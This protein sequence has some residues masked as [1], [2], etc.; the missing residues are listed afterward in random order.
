MSEQPSH[1]EN[2]AIFFMGKEGREGNIIMFDLRS[3]IVCLRYGP[4]K[5]LPNENFLS[6]CVLCAQLYPTLCDPMNCSPPGSTVY[7]ISQARILGRV[8][9]PFSKGSPQSRGWTRVSVSCIGRQI[10]YH[11]ATWEVMGSY[12]LLHR[13]DYNSVGVYWLLSMYRYFTHIPSLIL[14][15]CPWTGRSPCR[16]RQ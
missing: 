4:P 15:A 12:K 8:A 10:L 6:V 3:G 13:G 1:W 11:W 5:K 7:G 2:T 14:K 16:P 9:I